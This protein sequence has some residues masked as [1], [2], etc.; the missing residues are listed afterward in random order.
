MVGRCSAGNFGILFPLETVAWDGKAEELAK[1]RDR[2]LQS[3]DRA[4]T[5]AIRTRLLSIA[6]L[7]EIEI[8]LTER[9][10][11]Y[12]IESKELIAKAEDLLGPAAKPSPPASDLEIR[13]VAPSRATV[14][15]GPNIS[16]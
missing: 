2:C 5:Q 13:I 8:D 3:A 1:V 15:Q 7:Y 4:P 6:H 14:P 11:Q 16:S 12:V 9:S 10:R